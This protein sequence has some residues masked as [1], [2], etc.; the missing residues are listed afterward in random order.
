MFLVVFDQRIDPE[1]VLKTIQVTAGGST[2]PVRLATAD[3]LAAD[4]DASRAA[5]DAGESR[6]LAFVAEEPLP[7][8]AAVSVTIG[9]GTPSA[10]GP[11]VTQEAQSYEF[12]H[13]RAAAHRAPRLLLVRR[14]VP[15][16]HPFFIEFNNPLDVDAYQES[17]LRIEPALPGATVDVAGNT[18][19]IHGATT[20]RTTYTAVVDGSIRDTFGQTL[21]ED[22]SLTFKVGSAEPALYRAR[23]SLSSPSTRRPRRRP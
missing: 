23:R 20:G 17:M 7:A 12:Q 16:A 3:E 9:P 1:A 2:A 22:A 10:E 11:L 19:T 6:W 13:L 21:G 15:A 18:I 4:K 14:R 5:A 8:D